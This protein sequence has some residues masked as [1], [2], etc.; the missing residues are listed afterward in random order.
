MMFLLYT[1]LML[2]NKLHWKSSMSTALLQLVNWRINWLKPYY[3]CDRISLSKILRYLWTFSESK[4]SQKPLKYSKMHI[5]TNIHK[6][7]NCYN[8]SDMKKSFQFSQLLNTNLWLATRKMTFFKSDH[9][10]I[11]PSTDDENEVSQWRQW[12]VWMVG[13]K[14]G[15]F[16]HAIACLKYTSRSTYLHMK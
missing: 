7:S 11:C 1:L 3:L 10:S 5:K 4:L 15:T 6:D 16:M 9:F 12:G 14:R 13:V 2:F 8:I